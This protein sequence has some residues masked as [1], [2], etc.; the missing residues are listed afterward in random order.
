MKKGLTREKAEER[1][2][3][4]TGSGVYVTSTSYVNTLPP[5]SPTQS[6]AKGWQVDVDGVPIITA[7]PRV[8]EFGRVLDES[9]PVTPGGL[10]GNVGWKTLRD[11]EKDR[12]RK[13]ATEN[14]LQ[15]SETET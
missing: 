3:G 11:L 1:V 6:T 13:Q 5:W 8:D 7:K 12:Y 4:K 9:P 15:N 10:L 14:H 2:S